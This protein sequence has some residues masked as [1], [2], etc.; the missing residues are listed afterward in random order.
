M[1]SPKKKK[2]NWNEISKLRSTFDLYTWL[3]KANKFDDLISGRQINNYGCHL[4]RMNGE[5]LTKNNFNYFY[6]KKK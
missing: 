1:L 3:N 5:N 4:S 2:Q 6:K